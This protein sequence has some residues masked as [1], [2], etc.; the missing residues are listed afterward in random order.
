MCVLVCVL[1]ESNCLF[2]LVVNRAKMI[3]IT[4]IKQ[5]GIGTKQ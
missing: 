5:H 3:M 4:E 2:I 1:V